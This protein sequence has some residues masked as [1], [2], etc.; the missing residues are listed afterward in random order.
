MMM[1]KN[2]EQILDWLQREK[3]K[4]FLELE[5]EKK[6][7]IENIKKIKKEDIL[8]KKPEKLSIWKRLK[9]MLMG[10]SSNSR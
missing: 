8:P 3:N 1:K 5:L 4:D 7:L 9:I 6:K 2:S 10:P